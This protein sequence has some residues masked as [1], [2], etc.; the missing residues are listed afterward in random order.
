MLLT[1]PS[2][3][4][5]STLL[6]PGKKLRLCAGALPTFRLRR[7]CCWLTFQTCRMPATAYRQHGNTQSTEL[8]D[9][10]M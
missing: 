8:K 1:M 7:G 5:M 10:G 9:A 3:K 2:W 4:V 6:L